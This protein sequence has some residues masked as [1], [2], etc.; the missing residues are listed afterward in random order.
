MKLKIVLMVLLVAAL[1]VAC[2][3]NKTNKEDKALRQR[4]LGEAFLAEGKYNQAYRELIKAREMNPKD[5]H[6]HY[7]LGIFF[8]N[9][10]KYDQA[11]EEYQKALELNSDF[12]AARNNLG[13]VYMHK[14]EWDMAI[15]TLQP[16]IEDYAYATPHFP[17]FILGQAYF[18]K[19]EY[20]QAARCF[21]EALDLKPDYFYA[22]HWLGKTEL[23][24]G[25]LEKA[26]RQIEKAVEEAPRVA[27]FYF[28]LGR[29]QAARGKTEAARRAFGQCLLLA[30]E[31]GD[32]ELKEKALQ[33]RKLLSR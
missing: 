29:A 10:K 25:N 31:D 9:K 14:E 7:D 6:V 19:K 1:S 11:I 20:D 2:A 27:V 15:E 22:R 24:Q 12:A 5:A 21:R 30:D 16:I 18:H 32:E 3:S 28:D 23:E 33:E 8:Y 26:V 13:V 4:K 17:N